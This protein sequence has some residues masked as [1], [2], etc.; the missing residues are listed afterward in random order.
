MTVY[1]PELGSEK[2]D[3]LRVEWKHRPKPS[4]LSLSL[5]LW[6]LLGE[7]DLTFPRGTE[8]KV[9]QISAKHLLSLSVA[10][11]FFLQPLAVANA[12]PCV[13]PQN[14]I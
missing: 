9:D 10:F 7:S 6:T 5:S 12:G 8:I 11:F 3:G 14:E 13:G 1:G 4:S 2:L